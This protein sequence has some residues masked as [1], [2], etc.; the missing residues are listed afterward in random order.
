MSRENVG[1]CNPKERAASWVCS[2]SSQL[3]ASCNQ[4]VLHVSSVSPLLTSHYAP[5]VEVDRYG[6][7]E[8]LLFLL[9]LWR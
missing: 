3:T 4:H 2:P 7:P 8:L 5:E 1:N 9:F 6:T